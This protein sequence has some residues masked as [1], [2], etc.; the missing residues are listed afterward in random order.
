MIAAA[1]GRVVEV[2]G[3]REVAAAAWVAVEGKHSPCDSIQF[4]PQEETVELAPAAVVP[5]R[6]RPF[7]A[8]LFIWKTKSGV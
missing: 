3:H 6:S 8:W 2:A 4:Y 1:D 5:G 7:S